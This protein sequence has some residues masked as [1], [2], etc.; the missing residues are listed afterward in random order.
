MVKEIS[1]H[2]ENIH[3]TDPLL[4]ARQWWGTRGKTQSVGLVSAH[5]MV[6]PL[7]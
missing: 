2:A 1:T 6:G 4:L 7:K 5:P 3:A